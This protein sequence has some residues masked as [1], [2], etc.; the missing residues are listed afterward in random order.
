MS[1]SVACVWNEI[2]SDEFEICY[3]SLDFAAVRGKEFPIVLGGPVSVGLAKKKKID[4]IVNMMTY[5]SPILRPFDLK[6]G[7]CGRL[8]KALCMA[9]CRLCLSKRSV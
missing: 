5:I 1:K 2:V 8:D 4:E 6:F 9:T 3:N 7:M